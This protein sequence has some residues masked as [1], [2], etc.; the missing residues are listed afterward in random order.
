MAAP[1]PLPG[2]TP[3]IVRIAVWLTFLNTWVLFE[4]IVVDRSGLWKYMPLYRVGRFC[5]WDVGAIVVISF[6]VW[7]SFRERKAA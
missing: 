1:T 4:E 6:I 2:R 5:P 3:R 7:W